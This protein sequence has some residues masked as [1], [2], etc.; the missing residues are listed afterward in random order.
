MSESQN[1]EFG[2]K[3]FFLN[4]SYKIR[5][6][7]ITE[8]RESEYEVYEIEN[9]KFAKNILRHNPNSILLVNTDSQMFLTTWI[10]F[11]K[12]FEQDKLLKTTKVG[13]LSERIEKENADMIFELLD[14]D[15][16][17]TSLSGDLTKTVNVIKGILDMLGAKGRRKYVRYSCA[18]DKSTQMFW[19][20]NEKM[21]QFKILD[22]SSVTL[23][24]RI[25]STFTAHL[26]EGF[27]LYDAQVVLGKRVISLN[28]VTYLLK[29]TPNGQAVIFLYE[30]NTSAAIKT[31]I[32]NFISESLHKQLVSAIN[33][34]AEDSTDYLAIAKQDF[35][36]L[37]LE[38]RKDNKK[39][40]KT[41]AKDKAEDKE[42][43]ENKDEQTEENKEEQ[44]EV[45]E[46]KAEVAEETSATEE[47]KTDAEGE[48]K[49]APAEEEK[50]EKD[51]ETS[52]QN[53]TE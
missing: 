31:A 43:A 26:E 49:E 44:K 53:K 46:E 41:A 12:S 28:L 35:M 6:H 9:Y 27:I 10:T 11:I 4:P 7:I 47:A 17:I 19:T 21:H 39:S 37:E 18:N 45:A 48:N 3:I 51:E 22:L 40:E 1:P 5:N 34:E 15:A 23:A 52:E 36:T 33:N 29:D 25:P 32:K 14:I 20:A 13:I 2:R 8:L 42:E 30:S 38:S 50:S 16:G 24:V